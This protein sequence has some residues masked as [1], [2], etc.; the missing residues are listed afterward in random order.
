[1]VAPIE[2]V[3]SVQLDARTGQNSAPS[4]GVRGHGTPG[5][6]E[7][8]DLGL[9]GLGVTTETTMQVIRAGW[10]FDGVADSAGA[11]GDGRFRTQCR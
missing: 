7:A 11:A 9:G 10:L 6:A 1:M 4:V 8:L 2:G 5:F 3:G